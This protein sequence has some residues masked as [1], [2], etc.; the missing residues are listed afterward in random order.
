MFNVDGQPAFVLKNLPS[1]APVRV[2]VD[3][4][5]VHER[6]G[7][8]PDAVLRHGDARDAT[9][10]HARAAEMHADD[11]IDW[12]TR[13]GLNGRFGPTVASSVFIIACLLCWEALVHFAHIKPVILPAP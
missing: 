6:A 1:S 7:R 11:A 12:Q 4:P 8:R 9:V 3:R 10:P 13:F 5:A 2:P